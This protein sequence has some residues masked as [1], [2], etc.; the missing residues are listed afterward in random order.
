MIR[1]LT[2]AIPTIN[3]GRF[4]DIILAF[5]RDNN[6]PVTVFV[7][8]RSEDE[9]LSIAERW[10]PTVIPLSNPGHFVAEGLIEQISNHCRT[11][12][13]LRLDD[14]ELPTLDMMKFVQ[15]AVTGDDAR[16]YAFPRLQCAVSQ[17]GRLMNCTRVSPFEHRQWRL[18]QPEK[19]SY[20][21]GL[22]TPGFH[23]RDAS[24]G[25]HAPPEACMIHL[26]WAVHSYESRKEKIERYDAH[27]PNSGT[28]WRTYYLY[29]EESYPRTAFTDLPLPE[30]VSLA[31]ALRLR[32]PDLCLK[33]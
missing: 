20:L 3:S 27:T 32:L 33:D 31:A 26:D 14:D 19:V 16:V 23:W 9:T 4:L 13:I 10:A 22:H 15:N 1:D 21:Q 11:K 17:S 18:Y 30:F 12:W 28:R 5:Y 29:E 24:D 25:I 8:D 2:V 6:I 7:D